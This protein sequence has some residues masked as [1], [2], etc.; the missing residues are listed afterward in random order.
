M[1]PN[2]IYG[3]AYNSMR[4]L[5]SFMYQPAVSRLFA[6]MPSIQTNRQEISQIFTNVIV[7]TVSD[8]T[9]HYPT[10]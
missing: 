1:A 5:D 9:N 3:L 10:F 4:P 7:H 2:D 8:L 6:I